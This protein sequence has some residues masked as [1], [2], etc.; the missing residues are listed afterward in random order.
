[1]SDVAPTYLQCNKEVQTLMSVL[2]IDIETY[3][4][5]DLSSSGVYAYTQSPDFEILL[6]AYAWNDGP[7]QVVDLTGGE[8]IPQDV[9]AAFT[10]PTVTKS[11]WNAQFERVCLARYLHPTAVNISNSDIMP[12]EQWHCS[13][14]HSMY[15]GLPGSLDLAAKALKLE[16]EKDAAGRD[17]IRYFSVPCAPTKVNGGRTRN[18]PEHDLERW[19]HF[20]AYCAQDVEVERAIRKK[21]SKFPMPEREHRIWCLDQR[22][23]ETGVHVDME[24]VKNAIECDEVFQARYLAEAKRITGLENPNS[25]AQLKEWLEKLGVQIDSLNRA[26]VNELIETTNNPD[27]KRA[28]RLRLKMG[29][30]SVAKYQAFERSTD[31]DGRARGLM[32]F[33]GAARSGR[34]AGR[35][36]QPQNLPRTHLPDLDAAR[37]LLRSG[38]Y[39]SLELLYDDVPYVLSQLIRTA[40]TASPGCYL[41]VAD[42]S[43]I[44]AR[45]IAW[46]AG[47]EWAIKEFRGSG[48]IYEAT[49]AQ[50]FG[51]PIEAVD[52]D[53]RTKGKVATLACGYQGGP[54]AL[55]AMGALKSGLTE[56]EL[57]GIVD[58]WR[59][60]NPCIVQFWAD[61]E[62][63]ALAAVADKTA[64]NLQHGLRFE[65]VGGMLRIRLPSG[66]HLHYARPRIEPDP[67]FGK[68]GITY[69]G[70]DGGG[71]SRLRT[72]GGKLVENICQAVARDCLAEALLRIHESPIPP[73]VLHVHDEVVIDAPEGWMPVDEA[74]KFVT[75]TMSAPMEWAPGLPLAA[76]AFATP[77]YRT[78]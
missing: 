31:P 12:P 48:K 29:R 16:I 61:V 76:E 24:L 66:R 5:V 41:I 55:I 30:S 51:V 7:V 39:D 4:S 54:N 71:W 64:V 32:Q 47:E 36:V 35:R 3:S 15:L 33:Y 74:L 52:R 50:M 10:D 59:A 26:T 43:A 72:Y 23:N 56:Q 27:V 62:K 21:L 69:E 73:V 63:A 49:A 53:L 58:R 42:Y 8:Q 2:A 9:L 11:A 57:P 44:E 20:K 40:I 67:Q 19:K 38:D 60:A 6:F 78:D 34:W 14:V 46:L 65:Y 25:V 75:D 77:Y 18:R 45:V 28:L 1:M 22:I 13:M 68:D 70:N 37:Q 17:L